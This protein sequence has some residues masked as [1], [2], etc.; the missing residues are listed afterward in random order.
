MSINTYGDYLKAIVLFSGGKDSTYALHLA[1]LQGYDIALLGSIM[2]TYEYSMLYHKPDPEVLK[3]QAES[4]GF[5]IKIIYCHS[6][7]LEL[8]ALRHLLKYA[9]EH[10]G[11]NTVVS[12][13]LLSDY[14]RFRYMYVAWELGLD[15]FNPLWGFDQEKYLLEL[16]RNGFEF[17]IISINVYGLPPINMGKVIGYS[18]ALEIIGLSRKYGFNPSFEGGEAETIVLNAPLFRRRIRVDGEVVVKGLY[19]YVYVIKNAVLE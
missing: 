5:P 15:V 2:P 14:Q 9:V 17:M 19:E 13:A 11:V 10:Y 8:D 16:V 1:Y 4:M 7:E 3:L 12:G 6:Q 18:D